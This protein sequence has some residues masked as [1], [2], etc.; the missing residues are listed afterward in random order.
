MNIRQLLRKLLG[1]P[2]THIR[3]DGSKSLELWSNGTKLY[4]KCAICGENL[5]RLDSIREE[6]SS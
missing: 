2:C 1:H 5:R 4:T 6:W 3:P